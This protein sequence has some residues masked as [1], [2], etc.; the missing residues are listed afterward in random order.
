MNI[1]PIRT[2]EDY[3]QAIKE[4]EADWETEFPEGSA[5]GERYEVLLTLVEAYEAKSFPVPDPDPIEAIKIRL[6]DKGLDAKDLLPV[7]GTRSRVYEVMKKIRGLSVE[8]IRELNKRLD[9]PAEILLKKYKLKAVP[10]PV[11]SVRAKGA[12]VAS[13]SARAKKSS[14]KASRRAA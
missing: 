5:D 10:H 11:P 2:P 1:K 9:I 4:V 3:A 6:E 7:F 12:S 14:K 8:H 13:S